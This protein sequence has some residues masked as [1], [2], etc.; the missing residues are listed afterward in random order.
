MGIPHPFTS[1]K[2]LRD[3]PYEFVV[4]CRHLPCECQ[5]REA[6][7]LSMGLSDPGKQT[8]FQRRGTIARDKR[9]CA[10]RCSNLILIRIAAAGSATRSSGP[11]AAP[12]QPTGQRWLQPAAP[13]QWPRQL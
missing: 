4:A 7:R 9:G 12:E 5:G 8:A 13:L 1:R 3:L 11:W 2:R 6:G 10:W